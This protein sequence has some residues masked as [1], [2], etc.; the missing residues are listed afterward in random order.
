MSGDQIK[1]STG[2]CSAAAPRGRGP[3]D[4]E[5]GGQERQAG[6]TARETAGRRLDKQSAAPRA[7]NPW[8]WLW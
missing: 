8:T 2:R 6:G 3:E 1:I 4:D 7:A 5:Q